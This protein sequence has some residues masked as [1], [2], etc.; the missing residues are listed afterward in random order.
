M[1]RYLKSKPACTVAG[2]EILKSISL[3]LEPGK[4]HAIMG[5]N[6]TGKSTLSNVIAGRDGYEVTKGEV[7]FQGKDVLAMKAD[8]QRAG[9]QFSRHRYPVENPRRHHLGLLLNGLERAKRRAE[10]KTEID[11]CS[12][13][14][15]L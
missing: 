5:P 13:S 4:V 9:Q 2:K 7:L 1:Y 15:R 12:N 14:Y 6:G 11:T 10:G 3:S 8:E